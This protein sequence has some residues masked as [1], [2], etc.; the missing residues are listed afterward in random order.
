MIAK[1]IGARLG[2]R[3][4]DPSRLLALVVR[5]RRQS[6]AGRST[7]LVVLASCAEQG[8]ARGQGAGKAEEGRRGMAL[9]STL[10]ERAFAERRRK[11]WDELD[12]ITR[13]A[14]GTFFRAKKLSPEDV[15]RLPPLYRNVCA[16]LAASQS[17]A[18]QRSALRRLSPAD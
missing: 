8:E 18:L 16:D 17:C 9:A 14:T 2:Y 13:R 10:T 6:R 4:Q 11:D 7:G 15:S 5:S 12:A 1:G 3:H